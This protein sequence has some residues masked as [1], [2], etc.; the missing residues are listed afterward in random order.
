ME[1]RWIHKKTLERGFQPKNPTW[2]DKGYAGLP[3]TQILPIVN[4]S[5][6]YF[7]RLFCFLT[8][9]P[10]HIIKEDYFCWIEEIE[11][12]CWIPKNFVFDFA[13]IPKVVPIVNP[14]GVFAYAAV[15]HDFVYRFG[16]LLLSKKEGESF[17]AVPVSKWKGDRIFNSM[18]K[19]ANGLGIL[20]WIATL[21][22]MIFGGIKYRPKNIMQV[23]WNNLVR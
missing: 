19:Q 9:R 22:L 2:P 10:E 17:E 21:F 20:D 8:K 16:C 14:T 11:A 23:D 7:K 4:R 1:T 3:V 15:P 5:D 18:A 6:S 12:W 13:S